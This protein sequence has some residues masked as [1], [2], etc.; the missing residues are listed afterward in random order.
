MSSVSSYFLFRCSPRFKQATNISPVR[1]NR[2]TNRRPFRPNGIF[3]STI[4][5]YPNNSRVYKCVNLTR[6]TVR[7]NSAL[8]NNSSLLL[9]IFQTTLCQGRITF[10]IYSATHQPPRPFVTLVYSGSPPK[11]TNQRNEGR[12]MLSV[13]IIQPYFYSFC[14]LGNSLSDH[15]QHSRKNAHRQNAAKDALFYCVEISSRR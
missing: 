3:R 2:R 6:S 8:F 13:I 7:H 4:P 9:A 11:Q 1:P 10:A 5:N 15:A 14:C 12:R